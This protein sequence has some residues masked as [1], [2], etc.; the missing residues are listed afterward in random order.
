MEGRDRET[1]NTGVSSRL[2]EDAILRFR[3]AHPLVHLPT[4]L[5]ATLCGYRPGC[6]VSLLRPVHHR[7]LLRPENIHAAKPGR[8]PAA[9]GTSDTY[10]KI[11][12]TAIFA[13]CQRYHQLRRLNLK[14]RSASRYQ[15]LVVLCLF[16][17]H[18]GAPWLNQF[19]AESRLMAD[20]QP[21]YESD[22][23]HNEERQR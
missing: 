15:S 10:C 13:A 21:N 5:F 22:C 17:G 8:A 19:H 12:R 7:R 11:G 23:Q 6:V 1:S 2:S 9:V 14:A 3:L 4:C 18:L 20:S 16:T